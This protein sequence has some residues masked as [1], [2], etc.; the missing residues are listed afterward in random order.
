MNSPNP[1]EKGEEADDNKKGELAGGDG[2][3]G[4]N[5]VEE[6]EELGLS[7]NGE[8]EARRRSAEQVSESFFFL[9]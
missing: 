5:N 7:N 2:G 4:W 1:M 8:E 9:F 3:R 6:L